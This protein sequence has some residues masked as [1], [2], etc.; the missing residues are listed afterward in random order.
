MTAPLD[1]ARD[2]LITAGVHSMAP[3]ELAACLGDSVSGWASFA[4][5]WEQLAPDCYAAELGT[6]RLRRYG[7]F[8]YADGHVTSMRHD[9]FVQPHLSNPLYVDRAR[10]FEPLTPQFVET[11]LLHHLV[12][13][14]GTLAAALED[15]G[16]W[17][18]RVSPFRVLATADSQ[19]DPAPEGRHRDGVTLVSSMLIAR[20]NAVGGQ[21]SVYDQRGRLLLAAT[22][23]EPGTILLGDDR[24][25]MHDVSPIRPIDTTHPARRD[26]V[27]ITFAPS[28][29]P[30]RRR[31]RRSFRRVLRRPAESPRPYRVPRG[32]A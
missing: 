5:H 12:A 10:H 20:D 18:V 22:L 23:N 13:M 9:A 7:Q 8:C 25:T 27:V 15:V 32:G 19:G 31:L 24:C 17:S 3:A 16:Q 30:A 11:P 6:T 4:A 26:V 28:S 29:G 14:L 2:A 1:N 21:S